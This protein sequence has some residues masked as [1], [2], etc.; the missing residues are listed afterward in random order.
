MRMRSNSAPAAELRETYTVSAFFDSEE[1]ATRA[2]MALLNQG[3]PRSL[4]DVA[5]S[6]AANRRFF[7]GRGRKYHDSTF[8][9][10]GRG[11]LIG[12][13]ISAAFTLA[14]TILPG[15]PEPGVLAIVQLF[16]P[17]VG[18]VTGGAF[19]ALWALL[20]RAHPSRHYYRALEREALL[21]LVQL[22]PKEEVAHI[23]E[24]LSRLGGQEVLAVSDSP[25][26]AG[27]E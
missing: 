5:V 18:V 2:M 15:F 24:L 13:L 7:H 4:I 17:N 10:A 1:R 11:A 14:I 12:L 26:A 23:T 16:G 3:I 27:R 9:F 6:E 21:L 22:R 19:G 20:R 8:S 25:E